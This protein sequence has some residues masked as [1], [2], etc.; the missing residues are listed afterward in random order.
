MIICNHRAHALN[1]YVH[2]KY[3]C[4]MQEVLRFGVHTYILVNWCL[5]QV[6]MHDS[7][8]IKTLCGTWLMIRRG[9]KQ[10]AE[11][12]TEKKR[13]EK[14]KERGQKE[15]ETS[16]GAELLIAFA[17][18]LAVAFWAALLSGCQA[19]LSRW[20]T[21]VSSLLKCDSNWGNLVQGKKQENRGGEW[22]VCG[23]QRKPSHE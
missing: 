6:P 22:N 3:Q 20:L 19:D 1:M 15:R 7:L 9:L 2:V 18:L 16:A 12:T 11:E 5:W 13:R 4:R 21:F 10:Q 23:L 17:A 14:K 8:E